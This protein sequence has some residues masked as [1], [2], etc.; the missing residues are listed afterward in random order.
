VQAFATNTALTVQAG[1]DATTQASTAALTVRGEDVT[2][3]S[4][5]SLTG[6]ATTVR[7]GNNASTGAS[8]AAGALTLQAGGMTGASTNLQGADVIVAS[9]L[10]TGNAIASHTIL[11]CPTYSQTTGTAAQTLVACNITIKT[12][13][14]TTSATAT[15]MFSVPATGVSA[16]GGLVFVHVYTTQSTPHACSDS[17]IWEYAVQ[18]DTS[19]TA[20]INRVDATVTTICDTGTLTMTAAMTNANPSVFS[21]TPSWATIVPTAVWIEITI[22]NPSDVDITLISD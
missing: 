6:G 4:T 13:G 9:G 8:G 2:G 21:V 17:G 19:V 10:G 5:A 11:K 12:K 22:I 7:G 16:A 20:S 18:N 15:N 3:G 1:Q 14:S